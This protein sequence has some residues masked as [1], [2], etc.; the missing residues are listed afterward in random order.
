MQ[1]FQGTVAKSHD[2]PFRNTL[3][4]HQTNDSMLGHFISCWLFHWRSSLHVKVCSSLC[5]FHSISSESLTTV[6]ESVCRADGDACVS[7]PC[8]HGGLCKDSI[9]SYD[10][11]CQAGYQGFNCEIGTEPAD[12][13]QLRVLQQNHK[14]P[15]SLQTAACPER[16]A[17]PLCTQVL[18]F[19]VKTWNISWMRWRSCGF[20]WRGWRFGC[21]FTG[22]EAVLKISW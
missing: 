12:G 10:C 11:Y 18:F 2:A 13:L 17:F 6:I 20:S 22:Q 9:G 19:S 7:Q 21:G 14:H 8:A 5:L 3:R 15:V 1:V 16:T 4:G